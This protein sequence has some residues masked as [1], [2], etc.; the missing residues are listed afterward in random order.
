M[1]VTPRSLAV[2]AAV[3]I[4]A[5]AGAL[6]AENGLTGAAILN[7]PIAARASGMGRAFAAIPGDPE[8]VM[9]NPAGPGFVTGNSLN[10]GYMNG[11]GGGAYGFAAA[12]IKI[13]KFVLTPACIYY[14]SGK[15][16]LTQA[17]VVKGEVT[18]ELDKTGIISAA[19]TPL[20]ALSVGGSVKFTS[21]NLA[22]TASASARQYDLG[23]LWKLENGLSFGAA[24][25]N[26]GGD[27]KFEQK[28]DPAPAALRAGLAYK[29]NI[30]QLYLLDTSA[31]ISYG[32]V[33]L[34]ADW[35][36][37]LKEKG[38]YQSGLEFN[39]KMMQLAM[40]ALR[41]GYMFNRAEEGFTFGFG[42]KTGSWNFDFGY[43][44]SKDLKSRH[45]A[46]LSYKF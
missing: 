22:Q 41:F 9:F 44:I 43:E 10:V 28:G 15:M 6:R 14:D 40:L 25:L 12:P 11:F 2:L 38:Y 13:N 17:D 5:C 31:D 33:V 24:S 18:A 45:P 32:D 8:S 20:P 29:L 35:S 4:T 16:S 23:V 27:I 39:M 34:T 21:I 3:F 36:R 37:V 1:R 42:V 19:Y 46:A 30:T 7:R 26:N